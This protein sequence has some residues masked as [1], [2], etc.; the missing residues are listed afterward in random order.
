MLACTG[1]S[2]KWSYS[3]CILNVEQNCRIDELDMEISEIRDDFNV[4]PFNRWKNGV[5]IYQNRRDGARSR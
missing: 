4:S 5:V 2:E 3:G 1:S